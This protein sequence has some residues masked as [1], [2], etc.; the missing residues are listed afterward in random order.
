MRRNNNDVEFNVRKFMEI[1]SEE[2]KE[3]EISKEKCSHTILK[4]TY[5]IEVIVYL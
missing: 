3:C 4:N 1:W 5:T 2:E